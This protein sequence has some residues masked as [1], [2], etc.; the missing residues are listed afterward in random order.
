LVALAV[1]VTLGV[2][3]AVAA[4]EP[5][6]VKF[7]GGS[8]A[9]FQALLDQSPTGAVIICAQTQPLIVTNSLLLRKP[10]TV[11]N[12][13][14]G[15]APAVGRMPLLVA[16]AENI[17]LTGLDLH[18]N[19]DSVNQRDRAPLIHV[20]RG[21]F[22][23]ERCQF[24]DASKDGIMV[25]PDNGTGDIVRGSIRDIT[26]ARIGRDLVSLSGGNGGQRIR[27]VTV[28]NVHLKKGYQ[29]GAVEVSDGADNIT[30]RHVSAA[31]AVYA[32]DVQDH[33]AVEK[34]TR[35]PCAPNTRVLI[36]DVTAVRCKHLIRTTNHSPPAHADLTLRDFT[37]QNCQ[38]PVRI[39]NTTR[40]LI[41]NLAITNDHALAAAPIELR[42][43]QQVVIRN[44]SVT[45]P[46]GNVP[47][48]TAIACT[49][50]QLERV[51][52][53]G[54]PVETHVAVPKNAKTKKK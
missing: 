22:R 41:E 51:T 11:R 28:E 32:I 6:P 10:V 24:A 52:S 30:V 8:P 36:E 1:A 18:G 7:T 9:A 26:G 21:G 34:Q 25:T 43:N 4:T 33:G 3:L 53:N 29:R 48:V 15:L 5:A 38:E 16:D 35:Q 54:T 2:V 14:A 27:D 42:N 39:S 49:G 13:K 31:D 37:V 12:L 50:V 17:S 19:Y 46:A 23:I 45:A 47:A 44:A 40:V 20:K